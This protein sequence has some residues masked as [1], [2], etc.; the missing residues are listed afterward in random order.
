MVVLRVGREF[1]VYQPF[2]ALFDLLRQRLDFAFDNC[3]G[4]LFRDA[5]LLV[6][7][8]PGGYRLTLLRDPARNI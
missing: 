7:N 6:G 8:A 1:Q 5:R 2:Q 3:P 4:K